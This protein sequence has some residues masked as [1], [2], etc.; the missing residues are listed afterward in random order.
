M[1]DCI[2][3]ANYSAEGR[4]AHP[5]YFNIAVY[6]AADYADLQNVRRLAA[7]KFAES[8][9]QYL[10][11]PGGCDVLIAAMRK[12]YQD[13]PIADDILRPLIAN[14]CVQNGDKLFNHPKFK[15]MLRESAE[16]ATDIASAY[17]GR[18]AQTTG[19]QRRYANEVEPW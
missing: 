10:T 1:L 18:R 9:E 15:P 4:E 16:L 13:T 2:Y 5:L 3:G 14:L 8:A 19:R 17:Q 12:A 11:S 6:A 7:K